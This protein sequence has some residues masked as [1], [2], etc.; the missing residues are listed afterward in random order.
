M[1]TSKLLPSPN[2]KVHVIANMAQE[3]SDMQ[4]ILLFVKAMRDDFVQ[5]STRLGRIEHSVDLYNRSTKEIDEL[6]ADLRGAETI[7]E[8][9]QIYQKETYEDKR[10]LE[11]QERKLNHIIKELQ[12][13]RSKERASKRRK[14]P[15]L[16]KLERKRA[17]RRVKAH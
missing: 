15:Q 17:S 13:A 4:T 11:E 7:I 8:Q 16:S 14:K 10:D 3:I 6:K 12:R 1:S 5:F 9:Q 2:S